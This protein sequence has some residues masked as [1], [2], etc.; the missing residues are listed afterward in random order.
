MIKWCNSWLFSLSLYFT[1]A[2]VFTLFYIILFCFILIVG[3]EYVLLILAFNDYVFQF[4]LLLHPFTH[5][6]YFAYF[7]LDSRALDS[8]KL[9][10]FQ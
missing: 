7:V 10:I 6:T 5:P 9:F 1:Q 2:A 4:V 8:P 3:D